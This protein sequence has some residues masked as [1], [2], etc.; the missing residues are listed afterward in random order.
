MLQQSIGEIIPGADISIRPCTQ[1][2][3]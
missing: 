3:K 1:E 2:P